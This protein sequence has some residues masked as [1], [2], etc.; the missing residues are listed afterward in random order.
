MRTDNTAL[1]RFIIVKEKCLTFPTMRKY[2]GIFDNHLKLQSI[3]NKFHPYTCMY[4]NE[5]PMNNAGNL[6]VS[7]KP[8]LLICNSLLFEP[9]I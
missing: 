9:G 5:K 2:F 7:E 1:A 6:K 8:K 3:T 4:L